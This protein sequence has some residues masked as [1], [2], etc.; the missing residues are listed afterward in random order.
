MRRRWI[1]SCLRRAP[2]LTQRALP[3]SSCRQ[4]PS[5][6]SVLIAQESTVL[7]I[8]RYQ[9]SAYLTLLRA[10]SLQICAAGA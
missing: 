10:N 8:S 4:T 9:F 2:P 6:S 3:T 7:S 5:D 1:R